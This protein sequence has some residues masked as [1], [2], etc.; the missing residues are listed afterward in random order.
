MRSS[1]VVLALAI[2]ASAAPQ[3]F[4]KGRG[5]FGGGFRGGNGRNGGN[6]GNGAA[7]A[8]ASSTAA[9]S[10]SVAT[11]AAASAA[12]GA[13][14]NAGA[15]AAAGGNGGAGGDVQAATTLDPSVIATGFA[16]DGQN[17]PVDGQSPSLTSTNNFI[18]FCVGKTITN[19][20]QIAAGSCNPAP[21]GNLPS[22]DKMPSSKFV[23]PKNNDVILSN[24][25]F[26]VQMKVKNIQLGNFVNAQANYYSAP[27]FLNDQ[28][29]IFGH[30]HVTIDFVSS[31]TDTEPTTPTSFAYFK[32]INTPADGNNIATAD[33]DKGLP[34]GTYRMAS[35]NAAAN[36]QPVLAPV[37][38]HGSL[39]DMVYFTV[40]DD[41]SAVTAGTGANAGAG[42]GAG[43]GNSTA[44][45]GAANNGAA[46]AAAGQVT[47]SAVT[48]AAAGQ[49]TASVA[50][51][52]ASAAATGANRGGQQGGFGRGQQGGFGRGRQGGRF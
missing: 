20:K 5:G 15:G 46:G 42:A 8:A 1:F 26:T 44:A 50:T 9:A 49:V 22:Q 38:Q 36:H 45:T 34:A 30:S 19:G 48:S 29:F 47:A 41:A 18:N 16:N 27:Q 31:V 13:A 17:P 23:F 51:T 39:D 24:T 12:T 11:T 10:T 28:G 14:N 7:G 32:G 35:I 33:I 3:N 37:A 2:A 21:M 43:A 6:G 52:A 40:T 25:A 4:G